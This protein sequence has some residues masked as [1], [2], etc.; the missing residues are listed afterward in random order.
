MQ[1]GISENMCAPE[2]ENTKIS[3]LYAKIVKQKEGLE[4]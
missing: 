4:Q 2:K 3:N 1:T